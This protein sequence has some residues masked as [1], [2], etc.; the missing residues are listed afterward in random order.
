MQP[1]KI[2]LILCLAML[3]FATPSL[4]VAAGSGAKIF[5]DACSDCHHPKKKP[6]DDT[7]LTKVEWKE[8]IDIMIEKD[9]IDP[10]LK[11][12]EYSILLDWLASTRG[13]DVPVTDAAKK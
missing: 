4:T 9:K 8:K 3:M 7:R 12:D 13:P 10:P 6:L 1:Y 5:E 11:A 2:P